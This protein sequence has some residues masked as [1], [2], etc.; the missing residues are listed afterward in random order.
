MLFMTE[1][2]FMSLEDKGRTLRARLF[3]EDEIDY[4]EVDVDGKNHKLN[5]NDENGQDQI[6]RMF[7]DLVELLES[8]AL[9]IELEVEGS[10]DSPLM[11]EVSES[12]ISDLNKELE[13][14]RAAILDE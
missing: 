4:L 7:C 14:L 13:D 12:Y 2:E 9:S 8:T 10:Y 5:L 11:K 3:K 6:K 1:E